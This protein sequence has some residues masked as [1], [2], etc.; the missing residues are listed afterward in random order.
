MEPLEMA[1][2]A[3]LTPQ[4]IEVV[5]HDDRLEAIPFDEPTDLVAISVQTFTARRAYEIAQEYRKRGTAVIMG[6]MHVTLLPDEAAKY[7]D[8]VYLGDAEF[9]WD[10]VVADAE[11]GRLK[12]RYEAKVGVPHPGRFPNRDIYTGKRYLPLTLLQFSRGCRSA[13]TYC[14]TSAYSKQ[15]HYVRQVSEVI[16]EIERLQTRF[17]FFVD[18]NIVSDPEA[19]KDLFRALIPLKVKWVSQASID[20]TRDYELMDLM[21]RSGC[22]GN[23]IGFESLDIRNLEGVGKAPNYYSVE[24]QYADQLKI[25]R[26]NGLQTWAASHSL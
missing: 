4:H 23:V 2:L 10:R 14:A 11:R 3:G 5:L 17:L 24:S 7:A 1:V 21:V 25:L 18:D 13:C 20:M 16:E 8:S 26:N 15:S 6:G 9:L 12:P 19:A 22:L